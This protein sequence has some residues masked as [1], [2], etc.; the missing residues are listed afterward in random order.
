MKDIPSELQAEARK[1][2]EQMVEA[3]AEADEELMDKYL[4]GR[5]SS[6]RNR[7]QAGSAHAHPGQRDR[8]GVLC[9]TAFKNKGVQAMLDAVIEYMPSPVDVP[10]IKGI[11]DDGKDTEAERIPQG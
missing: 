7:D 3:A 1:Y 2:R 4:E 5:A 9:G 10:P 6:A 11:L 8:S